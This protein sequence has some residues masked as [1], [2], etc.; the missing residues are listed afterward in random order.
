MAIILQL[1]SFL[2][3]SFIERMYDLLILF[4]ISIVK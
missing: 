3:A 4:D 1:L 2:G